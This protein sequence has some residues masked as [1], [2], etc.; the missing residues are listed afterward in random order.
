MGCLVAASQSEEGRACLAPFS[1]GLPP[2]Q[3]CAVV[4]A[5]SQCLAPQM[6]AECGPEALELAFS[7]GNEYLGQASVL[8]T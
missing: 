5:S 8:G 2:E 3:L 4:N 6:F 1:D 7:A